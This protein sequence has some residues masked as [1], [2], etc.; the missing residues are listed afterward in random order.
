LRSAAT[1]ALPLRSRSRNASIFAQ[2]IAAFAQHACHWFT[3]LGDHDFFAALNG[4]DERA[5]LRFCLC[6]AVC[7]HRQIVI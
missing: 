4:F 7:A 6:D 5:Q 3:A 2:S 1:L